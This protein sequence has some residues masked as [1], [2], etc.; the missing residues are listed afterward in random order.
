V[1]EVRAS[2]SERVAAARLYL[3]TGARR[4]EGDLAKF[5]DAVLGAGVDVIQLREKGIEAREEIALTELVAAAARRHGALVATNDRADVARAVG[6]DLLHLGQDDLPL[7]VAHAVAPAAL[8]GRSTHDEA[9]AA[10]ADVDPRVGY[11]CV[12]PTWSTPTKPGRPPAGVALVRWAAEHA[13]TPWFAIGGIEE[14]E[15][16]DAVLAA[17]ATRVVVVRALTEAADPAAA[18]HRLRARLPA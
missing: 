13:S 17:G 8:L 7:D 9:Q 16:L 3:C 1:A 4:R 18:A 6:A 12:G 2:A 11:F 10:T 15:R 5:L 14:G